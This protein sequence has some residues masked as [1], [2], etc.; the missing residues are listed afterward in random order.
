MK[1]LCE[2]TLNEYLSVF[3]GFL[4]RKIRNYI[5]ICE[6]EGATINMED[7]ASKANIQWN[8]KS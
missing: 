8:Q 1:N 3:D 4:I 2:R 7:E 5:H 6:K